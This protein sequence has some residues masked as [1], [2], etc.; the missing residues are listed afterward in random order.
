MASLGCPPLEQVFGE[1]DNTGWRCLCQGSIQ[2]TLG[3]RDT[4]HKLAP[5]CKDN[6]Q[7]GWDGG[8]GPTMERRIGAE[9]VGGESEEIRPI[10]RGGKVAKRM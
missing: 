3:E 10:E 8:G 9:Q 1:S 7:S 6:G 5:A 4:A 2:N